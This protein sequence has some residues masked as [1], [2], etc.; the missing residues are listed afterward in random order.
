MHLCGCAA[1]NT[2][3]PY[4]VPLFSRIIEEQLAFLRR[5]VQVG[6]GDVGFPG[7]SPLA[8][9]TLCRDLFEVINVSDTKE[10]VWCFGT[11]LLHYSVF[12]ALAMRWRRTLAR[13]LSP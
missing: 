7:V 5:E 4:V 10:I 11:F 6:Y 9:C 13:S 2:S 8:S 1:V 3:D 12:F